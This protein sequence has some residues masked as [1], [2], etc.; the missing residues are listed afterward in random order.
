MA[1]PLESP[2]PVAPS[3]ATIPGHAM[4]DTGIAPAPDPSSGPLIGWDLVPLDDGFARDGFAW[5]VLT[6]RTP[7]AP[8]REL[9]NVG[10]RGGCREA[11]PPMLHDP[12]DGG[13]GLVAGARAVHCDSP[14]PVDFSLAREGDAWV[15]LRS[16][17]AHPSRACAHQTAPD[18]LIGRVEVAR[19]VRAR[20]PA[21]LVEREQPTAMPAPSQPLGAREVRLR[22]ELGSVVKDAT[23]LGA[24]ALSLAVEGAVSR[25][26]EFGAGTTVRAPAASERRDAVFQRGALTDVMLET[27]DEGARGVSVTRQG[28]VLRV[29]VARSER[30]QGER[31]VIIA[32]RI[33]LPPGASVTVAPLP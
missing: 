15:I 22:W 11:P 6:E 7:D 14:E 31:P 18:A 23:P 16:G 1:P 29:H 30:A 25:R 9:V 26:I 10:A 32:Q 17:C 2:V 12:R 33:A 20:T 19:D 5:L 21:P 28:E 4:G 8:P 27:S 24:R 3:L 13:P